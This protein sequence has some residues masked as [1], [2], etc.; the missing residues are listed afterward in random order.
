MLFTEIQISNPVMS[1]KKANAENTVVSAVEEQIALTYFTWG[2]QWH[3]HTIEHL[4]R[5]FF[6]KLV[7]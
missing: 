5:F 3:C 1:L 7:I 6:F 4:G 2:L